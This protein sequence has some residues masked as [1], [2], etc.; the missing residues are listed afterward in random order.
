MCVQRF[1]QPVFVSHRGSTK[2]GTG[3]GAQDQMLWQ[4]S[5][6]LESNPQR[7]FGVAAG[8]ECAFGDGHVRLAGK[9]PANE[10]GQRLLVIGPGIPHRGSSRLIGCRGKLF[11]RRCKLSIVFCLDRCKRL[12]QLFPRRGAAVYQLALQVPQEPE[13]IIETVGSTGAERLQVRLRTDLRLD[14]GENGLQFRI[15]FFP[16]AGRRR[17][18]GH[19]VIE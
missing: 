12:A 3:I 14:L 1:D 5:R 15:A 6:V 10:I 13:E 7:E 18:L 17:D 9:F 2:G 16:Q 8:N 4:G 11:N 19:H